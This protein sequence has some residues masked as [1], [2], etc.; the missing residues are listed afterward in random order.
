MGGLFCLCS[1]V[2]V[3]PLGKWR[4][5]PLSRLVSVTFRDWISWRSG[6]QGER[7]G[8]ALLASCAIHCLPTPGFIVPSTQTHP[9]GTIRR[10]D[11]NL[12]FQVS[13]LS[14]GAG[15]WA[16]GLNRG[17]RCPSD[18]LARAV[19]G[20]PTPAQGQRPTGM[21]VGQGAGSQDE[22]VVMIMR[23]L[24]PLSSNKNTF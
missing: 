8:G 14:N 4:S 2:E 20:S 5:L 7:E 13:G 18:Y 3:R 11:R 24:V 22:T 21:E 10:S 9:V 17:W 15:G 1:N 16:W 19:Q 12:P 23:V 6:G